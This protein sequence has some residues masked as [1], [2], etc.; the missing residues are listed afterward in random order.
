MAVV[1]WLLVAGVL[2]ALCFTTYYSYKARRS[3]EVRDRGLYTARMNISMG[4]MLVL[5]SLVQMVM[6]S[7]STVRMI[8]GAV[9]LV[10]GLFNLFAGIRNRTLYLTMKQ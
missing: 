7:G 4:L 3:H 5:L 2:I 9:F 8:V 1:Q 6:F 10:L